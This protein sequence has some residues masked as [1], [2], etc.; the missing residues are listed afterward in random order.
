MKSDIVKE[1]IKELRKNQ[2]NEEK[3]MWKILRN[4]QLLTVKF[5]RQYPIEFIY[6]Q[7]KHFYVADF[8]SA[9]VNLIIEIDGN[10]H[11]IQ[12]DKDSF[13]DEILKQLGY[14]IL[15]LKNDDINFNID[16]VINKI[17]DCQVLN[18]V[19]KI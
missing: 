19:D 11:L 6:N 10:I 14:K 1:T 18:L 3:I 15:R 8:Y 2:T 7:K 17:K 4:K 13:R 16:Y 5:L 12:K 9:K